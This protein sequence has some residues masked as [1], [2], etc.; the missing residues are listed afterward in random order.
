[1]LNIT[2]GT[3]LRFVPA[4]SRKCL[5][6]L[7][8]KKGYV[9]MHRLMTRLF[10]VLLPAVLMAVVFSGCMYGK[11]KYP[12]DRNSL[13]VSRKGFKGPFVKNLSQERMLCLVNEP[14]FGLQA[15][16]VKKRQSLTPA[17]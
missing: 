2:G 15:S 12:L 11:V 4:V 13:K 14:P 5:A 17:E 1:M 9:S 3:S 8:S 7:F 6:G 10:P 16:T